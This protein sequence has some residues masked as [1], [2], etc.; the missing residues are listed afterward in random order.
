[1]GKWGLSHRDIAAEYQFTAFFPSV[2]E[3]ALLYFD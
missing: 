1:M 2:G 3:L